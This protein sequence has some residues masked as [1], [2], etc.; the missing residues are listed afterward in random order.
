[1]IDKTV[2]FGTFMGWWRPVFKSPYT[3]RLG[4]LDNNIPKLLKYP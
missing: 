3:A 1:M 2:R 4:A